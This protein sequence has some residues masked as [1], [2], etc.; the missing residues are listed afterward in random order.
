MT[1]DDAVSYEDMEGAAA[2][3]EAELPGMLAVMEPDN[4]G[5]H[6][7]DTIDVGMVLSGEVWLEL[8]DGETRKVSAGDV[9]IQNGTR[10][11][12]ENRAQEP[13]VMTFVLVGA[14]RS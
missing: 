12:W 9:V 1:G 4:P 14:H 8:D 10:H 2:G 11:R 6:T 13:C 3:L 5:M 7:T